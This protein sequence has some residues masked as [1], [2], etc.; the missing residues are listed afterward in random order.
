MP[1]LTAYT[2][3]GMTGNFPD[4]SMFLVSAN[5]GIVG[6]TSEHYHLT[7]ALRIPAFF[8]ITKIDMCP[9]K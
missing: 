9:E 8:I 2:V 1:K 4:Y 6:M 3:F 5:K 7:L